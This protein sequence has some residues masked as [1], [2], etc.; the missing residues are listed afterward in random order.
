[1]LK[2]LDAFEAAQKGKKDVDQ[3]ALTATVTKERTEIEAKY[4]RDITEMVSD[5]AETERKI[6]V[7]QSKDLIA[8]RSKTAEAIAASQDRVRDLQDERRDEMALYDLGPVESS[9]LQARM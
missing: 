2:E 7:K 3:T 1:M 9:A 8:I 6:W 4:L 5:S